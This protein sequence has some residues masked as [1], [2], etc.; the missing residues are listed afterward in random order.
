MTGA[1]HDV[2]RPSG[3]TSD[4]NEVWTTLPSSRGSVFAATISAFAS[5]SFSFLYPQPPNSKQ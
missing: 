5:P 3:M 1:T 2:P 4:L